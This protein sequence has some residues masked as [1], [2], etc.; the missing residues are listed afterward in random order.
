[1]ATRPQQISTPYVLPAIN[2]PAKTAEMYT[3]PRDIT[4]EV[5]ALSNANAK[6]A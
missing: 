4:S 6:I 5:P 1:M 3:Q 2:S